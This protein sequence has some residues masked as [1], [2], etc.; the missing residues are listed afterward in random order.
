MHVK[1]GTGCNTCAETWVL[2][3]FNSKHVYIP[4]HHYHGSSHRCLT[5]WL[6]DHYVKPILSKWDIYYFLS[7]LKWKNIHA[8]C[9]YNLSNHIKSRTT[10]TDELE[11]HVVSSVTITI[12]I[13]VTTAIHVPSTVIAIMT[14]GK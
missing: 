14:I 10:I 11:L 12:L 5:I 13:L 7:C 8:I 9:C 2:A 4:M 3:Q 6:L 1:E